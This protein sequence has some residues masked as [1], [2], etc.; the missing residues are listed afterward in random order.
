MELA[1]VV[2]LYFDSR[3]VS[4]TSGEVIAVLEDERE[5]DRINSLFT[6]P[7]A[8][9]AKEIGK[10][11]QISLDPD[12]LSAS[13]GRSMKEKGCKGLPSGQFLNLDT[14]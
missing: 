10:S 4:R 13:E 5:A 7:T 6:Q 1:N 9:L 3:A 14:I 2:F 11:R 12:V 8:S